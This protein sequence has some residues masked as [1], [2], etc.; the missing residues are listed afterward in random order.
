MSKDEVIIRFEDVSFEYGQNKPILEEV[1][2][3]VR[4][5]SKITIMGQNGAGKSTIFKLITKDLKPEEGSIHIGNGISIAISKQVIPREYLDLSIRDFFQM[6][7]KDKVYDIDPRIDEVLEVVNLH[8]PHDRIVRSF[9]GGQQ[10]RLLLASAIIQ[11][12]D[13]LLLDEPTNNL[14]KSGIY[15]I[16]DL[17][18][19]VL[20]SYTT[21]HTKEY[22]KCGCSFFLCAVELEKYLLGLVQV[23]HNLFAYKLF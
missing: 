7:F 6:S 19:L 20:T 16:F 14:D 8:A 5:G 9:S 22:T 11:N 13:I 12:P 3:S 4:K 15:A 1:N 23:V 2:F 18:M 21:S 17:A 10:A